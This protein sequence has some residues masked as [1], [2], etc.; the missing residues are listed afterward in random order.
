MPQVGP[1]PTPRYWG[2]GNRCSPSTGRQWESRMS[3]SR[4]EHTRLDMSAHISSAST[5]PDTRRLR[6]YRQPRTHMPWLWERTSKAPRIR[7]EMPMVIGCQISRSTH[8][9]AITPSLATSAG[10]P[11]VAHTF[12]VPA[13]VPVSEPG[14]SCF[15]QGFPP[16]PAL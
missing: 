14:A 12:Q 7:R 9:V 2:S 11:G 6:K 15:S 4:S 13:Q 8:R 3:N 16:I 1:S 5:S 10:L